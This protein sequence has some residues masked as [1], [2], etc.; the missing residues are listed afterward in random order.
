MLTDDYEKSRGKTDQNMTKKVSQGKQKPK[1]KKTVNIKN[2][3][4]LAKVIYS[5]QS[6]KKEDECIQ[7]SY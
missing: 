6:E 1:T 7:P 4:D 2:Q 3:N 5:K